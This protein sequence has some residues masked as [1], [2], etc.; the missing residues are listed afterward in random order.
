M[1]ARSP[2][3]PT[4]NARRSIRTKRTTTPSA[5][6]PVR[7]RTTRASGFPSTSSGFV[8]NRRFQR[9]SPMA[10]APRIR[11][12]SPARSIADTFDNFYVGTLDWVWPA[13]LRERRGRR[14][15]LRLARIGRRHATA[16][17]LRR[18]PTS[19]IPEIP[20]VPAERQRVRRLPV[21]QHD[22]VSTIS[23]ATP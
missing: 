21:Q 12:S 19:N 3:A 22:R 5:M 16:P 14:L 13:P 20:I 8:T 23:C 11:R 4:A 1:N 15:R 17:C 10:R 9:S 6:S 2:S 18:D 7:S